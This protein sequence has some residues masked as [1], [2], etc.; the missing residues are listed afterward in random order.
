GFPPGGPKVSLPGTVNPSGPELGTDDAMRQM[1]GVLIVSNRDGAWD[2]KYTNDSGKYLSTT[3]EQEAVFATVPTDGVTAVTRELP[4][5]GDYRLVAHQDSLDGDVTVTGLPLADAENTLMRLT[6]TEIFV[7][8]AGLIA[9]GLV[10]ES[11]IVRTL[12][13]LRRVAGTA[14]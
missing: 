1:P 9:V 6:L 12:R 4:G 2:G 13:P 5:L 10:G 7:A 14:T 11:I 3:P 8:L